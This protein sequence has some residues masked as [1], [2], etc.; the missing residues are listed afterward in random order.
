MKVSALIVSVFLIVSGTVVGQSPPEPTLMSA[1]LPRYPPIARLAKIQGEVKIDF[2]LNSNGEVIRATA[3]SG[4]PMLKPAAAETGK[5]WG[6]ETPNNLYRTDWK[7][8]TVFSFKIS[9]DEQPYE[10]AK[11]TVRI[12]S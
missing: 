9:N 7:Y 2:N 3:V 5:T 12:D 1:G 4:H 10:N 6:F 11:L 8:S